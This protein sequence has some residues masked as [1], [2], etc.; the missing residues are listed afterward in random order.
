MNAIQAFTNT[1]SSTGANGQ[2]AYITGTFVITQEFEANVP[3][4]ILSPTT[5][6][7]D[8]VVSVFRSSDGGNSWETEGTVKTTI[9]AIGS[10]TDNTRMINLPTGHYLIKILTGGGHASLTVSAEIA[11]TAWV[12]TAYS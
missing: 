3:I 6:S 2:S 12:I 11:S 7:A 10:A 9:S 4:R 8:A 5:W 1:F